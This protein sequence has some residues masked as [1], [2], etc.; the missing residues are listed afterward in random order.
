MVFSEMPGKTDPSS[1][2][3]QLG[4]GYSGR[5]RANGAGGLGEP[6]FVGT[7]FQMPFGRRS[8]CLKNPPFWTD[9]TKFREEPTGKWGNGMPSSTNSL[10]LT[11]QTG[12]FLFAFFN[13]QKPS[14][15]LT[16]A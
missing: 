14:Q 8:R 9:A 7:A 12:N 6:C 1:A 16:Y 5:Q 2:G 10:S 11:Q 3:T 4:K 13:R 15:T